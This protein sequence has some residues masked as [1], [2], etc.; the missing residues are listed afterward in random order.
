MP[1]SLVSNDFSHADSFDLFSLTVFTVVVFISFSSKKFFGSITPR[2]IRQSFDN[3]DVLM[4]GCTYNFSQDSVPVLVFTMR[5]HI[6]LV[7]A[8]NFW[9]FTPVMLTLDFSKFSGSN[10]MAL[11]DS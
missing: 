10:P 9:P 3:K 4:S 8:A 7:C 6:C 2:R 1:S 11:T 5:T